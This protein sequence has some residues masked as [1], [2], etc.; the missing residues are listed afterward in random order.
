MHAPWF[1][2][3]QMLSRLLRDV[4]VGM[5]GAGFVYVYVWVGMGGA[6]LV[7]RGH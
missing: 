7:G 1:H 5:G 6:G 2:D 4:W 3:V